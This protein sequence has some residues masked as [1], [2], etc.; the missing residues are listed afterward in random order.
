[1]IYE[2]TSE[3]MLA[4]QQKQSQLNPK[5][6]STLIMID[7][8]KSSVELLAVLTAI[9]ATQEHLDELISLGL[10][11]KIEEQAI[12]I[13]GTSSKQASPSS[14]VGSMQS[15]IGLS[16]QQRYEKAYPI[17][18]RL[19]AGLGLRGFRLNL[20]V[21]GAGNIND[22]MLLAGKIKE[23]VGEA[24]FEELKPYLQP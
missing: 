5:L 16:D 22:L 20:S 18:T 13:A 17:A 9:G 2:K 4:F 7:G 3:G 23:A 14:T 12:T 6:R 8:K 21:E 19:T 11:K 15:G 1:M 10:I 24:K